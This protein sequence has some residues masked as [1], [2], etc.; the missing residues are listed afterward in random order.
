MPTK[1]KKYNKTDEYSGFVYDEKGF[2][3]DPEFDEVDY[4]DVF[5][6]HKG[7][8]NDSRDSWY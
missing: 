8:N 4:S 6:D 3:I 5:S 2:K 7:K 1:R